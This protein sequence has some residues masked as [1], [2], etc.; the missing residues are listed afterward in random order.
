MADAPRARR[1]QAVL[2]VCGQNSIRSPMAAALAK[3]YFG[4]SIYFASAGVRKGEQDPFVTAVMDELGIDLS[5]HRPA[6]VEEREDDEGLNFDLVVSLSPQAHHRAL[7]LTRKHALDVEYWPTADPTIIEGSR[8][9]KL[10]AYRAVRDD[11][12]RN[13]RRRFDPNR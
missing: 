6:T 7:E 5:K 4:K 2:F 11:L 12:V 10:E 13:I 9:Q 1:P 8:D 3:H